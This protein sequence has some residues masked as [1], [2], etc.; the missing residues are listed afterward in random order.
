MSDFPIQV[1]VDPG[2]SKAKIDDVGR[3][4]EKAEK[5]ATA[6]TKAFKSLGEAVQYMVGQTLSSASKAFGSLADAIQ[7][8][9]NTQLTAAQRGFQ[10]LGQAIQHEQRLL[11]GIRGDTEA[12]TRDVAALNAMLAR[13]T[14]TAREHAAAVA[15]S[16]SRAGMGNPLEAVSLPSIAAPTGPFKS[17]IGAIGAEIGGMVGPAALLATTFSTITEEL[18]RWG[19]HDRMIMNATNSMLRFHDTAAEASAA[20]GEQIEAAQLLGAAVNDQ[21]EAFDAVGD[22]TDSLAKS[23]GQLMDVTRNLSMVMQI[24]GKGAGGVAQVMELLQVGLAKGSLEMRELKTVFKEA[25]PVVETWAASM[26]V[27][28]EDL[29]KLAERGKIGRREMMGFVSSLE[30][31]SEIGKKYAET[32]L[33]IKKVMDDQHLSIAEAMDVVIKHKQAVLDSLKPLDAYEQK[34]RAINDRINLVKADMMDFDEK[35][36]RA[37]TKYLVDSVE[38]GSRTILKAVTDGVKANEEAVA[39]AKKRIEELKKLADETAKSL[40]DN[41]VKQL[42]R[43]LNFPENKVSNQEWAD[44]AQGQRN[45]K[46]AEASRQRTLDA[47]EWGRWM[48]FSKH[49]ATEFES[50]LVN[51]F[52]NSEMSFSKMVDSFI[53]DMQR[54][55][56]RRAALGLG[57][58][59]FGGDT[60]NSIGMA[61]AAGFGKGLLGSAGLSYKVPHFASGGGMRIPGNGATDTTPVTFFAT[62][63]EDLIVRTQGQQM[64]AREAAQRGQGAPPSQ[65]AV[66]YLDERALLRALNSPMGARVLDDLDRKFPRRR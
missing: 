4:V 36:T 43:E 18:E 41:L 40:T 33:D 61:K 6:A 30:N 57:E 48:E 65:P 58:I 14:I 53:N 31:G 54:L 39:R 45:Q 17:A 29:F 15:Q 19:E 32:Q 49:E 16:R 23:H 7:Y 9:M 8:K 50:I 62:G 59:L 64:A 66:L 5:Q 10:S 63:G 56:L 20:L 42:D 26:G 3:T 13:G 12:Y 2:D 11:F 37:Q 51:A 52:Q 28:V 47:A 34:L 24:E 60:G 44:W 35:L 27:S 55:A 21:I 22:A 46:L 25:K 1:K 38:A